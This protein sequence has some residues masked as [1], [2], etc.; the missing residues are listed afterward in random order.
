[1]TG[2][3]FD[4]LGLLARSLMSRS[5][6]TIWAGRSAQRHRFWRVVGVGSVDL[7][8]LAMS[9]G[10][11]PDSKMSVVVTTRVFTYTCL[12]KLGVFYK[13][14]NLRTGRFR[15]DGAVSSH[16]VASANTVSSA[17]V[18]QRVFTQQPPTRGLHLNVR[19]GYNSP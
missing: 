19:V 17:P 7:R 2:R 10:N 11:T 3:M 13:P 5:A 4:N 15:L 8:N 16:A 1:V 9:S 12:D 14:S 6:S 18:A